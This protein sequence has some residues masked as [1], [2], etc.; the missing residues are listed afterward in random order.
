ETDKT[1]VEIEA[2][3]SGIIGS[4]RVPAGTEGLA[5]GTVLAIIEDK[6]AAGAPTPAATTPPKADA[7]RPEPAAAPRPQPAASTPPPAAPPPA[8]EAA[9]RP[10][11][12]QVSPPETAPLSDRAT[13]LAARM[14]RLAGVDVA[15]INPSSGARVTKTDVERAIGYTPP[16]TDA[17]PPATV[18]PFS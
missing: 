17:R 12:E 18:A 4:I 7:P 8:R 14:A 11:H 1:T 16:K 6:A 10:A 15:T 5:V 2:P 9:E 13:P 3:A